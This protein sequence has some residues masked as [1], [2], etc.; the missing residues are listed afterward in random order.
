MKFEVGKFEGIS[1]YARRLFQQCREV[2]TVVVGHFK[3]ASAL[4]ASLANR[5]RK[6]TVLQPGDL[7]VHRDPKNRSEG[8]VPW[9]RPMSG[10]WTVVSTTGNKAKLKNTVMARSTT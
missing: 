6:Q 10:P 8:R 4:R 7:V 2:K 3:N 9:K 5:F 1:D